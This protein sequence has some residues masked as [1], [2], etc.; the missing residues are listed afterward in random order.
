M[1]RQFMALAG[2]IERVNDHI[3]NMYRGKYFALSLHSNGIFQPYLYINNALFDDLYVIMQ[4]KEKS[5][6]SKS[7]NKSK[8]ISRKNN[9]NN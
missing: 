6:F 8:S 2:E 7:K 1:I 9:R 5:R 4:S 3:V